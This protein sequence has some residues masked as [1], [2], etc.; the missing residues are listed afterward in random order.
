MTSGP[1]VNLCDLQPGRG[2]GGALG[3][4]GATLGLSPGTPKPQGVADGCTRRSEGVSFVCHWLE[5]NSLPLILELHGSCLAS[6]GAWEELGEQTEV[7]WEPED[8]DLGS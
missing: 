1:A 8:D 2:V 6:W 3:N 7:G 5:K 4:Q